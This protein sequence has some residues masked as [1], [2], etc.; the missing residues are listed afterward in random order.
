MDGKEY[1]EYGS[2][3]GSAVAS[4]EDLTGDGV[5]DVVVGAPWDGS[6]FGDHERG[7]ALV[8]SGKTGALIWKIRGAHQ[9]ALYGGIVGTVGDYDRDGLAD[10]MMVG[11]GYNGALVV[12]GSTDWHRLLYFAGAPADV[13][14][15]CPAAVN[16][17]GVP[18]KLWNR[19]PIGLRTNS[20]ILVAEDLP[21]D[22]PTLL[23][24]G[25]EGAAAPF[26]A[27]WMCLANAP[28]FVSFQLA[29][30]QGRVDVPVDLRSPAIQAAN[31][32]PLRAGDTGTFQLLYRDG[33]TR[34]ATPALRMLFPD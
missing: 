4:G 5:P 22:A 13:D 31:G 14:T 28:A 3:F 19:G 30:S 32:G 33:T 26:G 18:A 10:W 34:N 2:G 25:A 29:N 15:L 17:T 1:S 23:V 16:S 7:A 8:F 27:G 20:L 11:L 21:S 24:Y 12:P 6:E 9:G